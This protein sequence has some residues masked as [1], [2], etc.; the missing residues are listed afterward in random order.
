M[1]QALVFDF[2]GLI[3]DTETPLFVAWS[4]TYEHYGVEP[5]GLEEWTRSLGRS[6]DDPDTLRPL[7]RLEAQIGRRLDPAELEGRRARRDA[8]V[9]AV[10]IQPGVESLL[11]EAEERGI[12]VGIASSSPPDWIDRHLGGRGLRSRF[13]F[14]SCA[15]D[16]VP[17]KPCPDVYRRAC[18]GLGADPAHTLALED[19]PNG[20][21][22]AKAAGLRCAVVPTDLG[23]ALAFP[24]ADAVLSSLLDLSLGDW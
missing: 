6:D 20:L 19:S 23:R 22:A 12:P 17:G 5:I 16:G 21:A 10:A 15:G 7:D 9:E 4:Q 2:D 13:A 1:L 8:L 14:V 11:V 18:T 24:G 3:L